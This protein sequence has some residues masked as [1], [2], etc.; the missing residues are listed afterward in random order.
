MMDAA[1]SY[2]FRRQ[3]TEEQFSFEIIIVSDGSTDHTVDVALEYGSKHG[4][5][6][7]RVMALQPN[8]GKG[9]AVQQVRPDIVSYANGLISAIATGHAPCTRQIPVDG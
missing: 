4:S 1:L 6:N 7:V 9:G 3:E 5:D 2:L 8:Q